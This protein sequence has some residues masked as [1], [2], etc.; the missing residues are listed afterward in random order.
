VVELVGV[1]RLD[2]AHLVGDV[3]EVRDGVRHP[4]ARLAMLANLRGVPM[5]LGR[6]GG[7]G[8]PLALEE[9]VGARLA[10]V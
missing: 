2:D 8:E 9:L 1:H 4:D 5:Q 6:A 3:V 10:V 7:E